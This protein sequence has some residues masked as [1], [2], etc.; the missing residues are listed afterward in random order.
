[1]I[2]DAIDTGPFTRIDSYVL[3]NTRILD[4]HEYCVGNRTT[5]WIF[6]P[7][8][9]EIQHSYTRSHKHLKP[10]LN[11][12][13]APPDSDETENLDLSMIHHTRTL[14]NKQ[15]NDTSRLIIDLLWKIEDE[16]LGLVQ[17]CNDVCVSMHEGSVTYGMVFL[18]PLYQE[19]IPLISIILRNAKWRR[20]I[21]IINV[22]SR[23]EGQIS[24]LRI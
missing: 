2:E 9:S 7:S 20:N 22:T 5:H 10:V 1:M 24:T 23:Y 3:G 6:Q 8:R 13:T 4:R 16:A 12:I 14:K 18:S 15:E 19:E 21:T 17:N 11:F